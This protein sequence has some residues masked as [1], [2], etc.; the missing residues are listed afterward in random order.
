MSFELHAKRLFEMSWRSAYLRVGVHRLVELTHVPAATCFPLS[1]CELICLD[2]QGG[3]TIID[4]ATQ[5]VVRRTEVDKVRGL[6][7]VISLELFV[8]STAT[9]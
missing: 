5:H 4:L 3:G 2:G 1:C 9:W 7:R 6:T 8:N